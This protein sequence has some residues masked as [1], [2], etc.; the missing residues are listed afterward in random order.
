MSTEKVKDFQID[1]LIKSSDD[2]YRFNMCGGNVSVL[3]FRSQHDTFK[4]WHMSYEKLIEL[5]KEHGDTY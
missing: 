2:T 1:L 5:F 3:Q 4:H